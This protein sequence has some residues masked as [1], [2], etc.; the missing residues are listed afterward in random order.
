LDL[1][2]EQSKH[3]VFISNILRIESDGM[4]RYMGRIWHLFVINKHNNVDY[5]IWIGWSFGKA[6]PCKA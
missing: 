4:R 5:D 1:I 6:K 2:F 3:G